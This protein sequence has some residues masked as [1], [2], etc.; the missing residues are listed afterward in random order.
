[1]A[2]NE[3]GLYGKQSL[4]YSVPNHSI[5]CDRDATALSPTQTEY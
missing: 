1:M 5:R 4:A 2:Y 3:V